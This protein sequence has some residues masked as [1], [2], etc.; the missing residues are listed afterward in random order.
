ME[1]NIFY[2][3][4]LCVIILGS[5]AGIILVPR[6]YMAVISLFCLICSSGFLYLS[7]NAKYMALFQFILCGIFL[8]SY[9]FILL[10]KINRLNLKLKLVNPIKIIASSCWILL[11]GILTCL[12]FNEEFNNSLY[13]IFNFIIE[14]SSDTI[15][16][17][18]HIFPL[19]LVILLVIVTSIILRIF[20]TTQTVPRNEE[21]K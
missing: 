18:E 2:F 21:K 13:S 7:L 6:M 11:F 9:I 1:S 19:H 10:K 14:K 20:L 3:Y 8:C 15:N 5:A 4:S 17:M 16:F 12:F